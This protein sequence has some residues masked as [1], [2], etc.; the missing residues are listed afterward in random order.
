MLTEIY[1]KIQACGEVPSIGLVFF[2]IEALLCH[3]SN[4]LDGERASRQSG[5]VGAQGLNPCCP[6]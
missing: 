2:L 6:H 5:T 4:A 1:R 3:S